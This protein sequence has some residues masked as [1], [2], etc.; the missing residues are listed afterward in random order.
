MCPSA[1]RLFKRIRTTSLWLRHGHERTFQGLT[2]RIH[3]PDCHL[4]DRDLRCIRTTN[5]ATTEPLVS[6]LGLPAA[7]AEEPVVMSA[8]A[9][10]RVVCPLVGAGVVVEQMVP[11]CPKTAC[12]RA[13]AD[14]P[15]VR[16]CLRMGRVK[17]G[18]KAVASASA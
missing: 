5:H 3:V 18:R 11:Y 13:S 17:T 14:L 4:P 16:V 1:T 7:A 15:V 2:L 12:A 6:L 10:S 9:V 8:G